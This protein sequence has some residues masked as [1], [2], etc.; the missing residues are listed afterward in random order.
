[1]WSK[2]RRRPGA[3][4]SLRFR[5]APAFRSRP[6]PR[7]HRTLRAQFLNSF[8]D[9]RA[10]HAGQLGQ[11]ANP[12]I[13]E[14]HRSVGNKEPCLELIQSAQHLQPPPLRHRRR[15]FVGHAPIIPHEHPIAQAPQIVKIIVLRPLTYHVAGVGVSA[16]T[17][18]ASSRARKRVGAQF[19][20]SSGGLARSILIIIIVNRLMVSHKSR[21][22]ACEVLHK[23]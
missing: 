20:C 8:L 16:G 9:G 11:A 10:R 6:G 22:S 21:I 3:I 23:C 2:S 13:P 15:P 17:S 18:P 19:R 12:S 7:P 1:M 5:P 4:S 14:L